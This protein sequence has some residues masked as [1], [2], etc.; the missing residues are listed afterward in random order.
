HYPSGTPSTVQ[1]GFRTSDGTAI[2]IGEPVVYNDNTKTEGWHEYIM[3]V[4][5]EALAAT[6]RIIFKG[7]SNGS[8]GS[9]YIDNISIKSYL[10]DNLAVTALDVPKSVAVGGDITITAHLLN[11]GVNAAKDYSLLFEIDGEEAG[12]ITEV[13]EMAAQSST[14]LSLT[15]AAHP[16]HGGS[17]V[18]VAAKVI[19]T[20][21]LDMA[22]NSFEAF[23]PVEANEHP[24]ATGLKGSATDH[25]VALSWTAPEVSSEPTVK[26]VAESFEDWEAY[27]TSAPEN[28]GWIF[29]D[30]DGGGQYGFNGHNGN[31]KFAAI[32]G[33]NY[34]PSYGNSFTVP[35]GSKALV[36]T[37]PYSYGGSNDNWVI[38]PEVKG[39]TEFSFSTS[40]THS[41]N[42]ATDNIEV[43]YSMGSTDPEEFLRVSRFEV[44]TWEWRQYSFTLPAAARRVA[45]R[46]NGKMENDAI[47]IDAVS[48]CV[49]D[50]PVVLTGYNVYRNH[51][52]VGSTDAA[53][54]EYFDAVTA[55]ARE[56]RSYYVTAVYDKGESMP[57]ESVDVDLST[58]VD[59]IAAGT[60]TI[61]V[62]VSGR[63]ITVT[64]AE[65]LSV[66]I[67]DAAGRTV[68][69]TARADESLSV[70]V[71]PG[72]YIVKAGDK[73]IKVA[74]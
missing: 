13:P 30:A 69:A 46:T 26:T 9:M 24:V 33:E 7:V 45:F 36:M 19:Y 22:D 54:A 10:A 38:L 49:E 8:Y 28:S 65:G 47:A 59:N 42:T 66:I 41:W 23:L 3:E 21:D 71:A 51:V 4:P 27:T 67:A 12:I 17:T 32:I 20:I 56:T 64:G 48:Y 58:G 18:S 40:A 53:T 72:V 60:G 39:G 2:M 15:V 63:A 14:A 5:A 16:R 70:D 44:K 74:L 52:K 6:T 57:S 37:K 61:S 31:T 1:A 68:F 55:L 73:A 29:I 62:S 34:T 11:K 35:D 50:A 25:A 43:Y